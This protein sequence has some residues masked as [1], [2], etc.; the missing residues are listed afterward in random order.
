[1]IDSGVGPMGSVST[2][3][4]KVVPGAAAEAGRPAEVPAVLVQFG[5]VPEI[6]RFE[7][8]QAEP[9]T[10]GMQ[11]VVRSHRGLQLGRL[12]Q[13]A[14]ECSGEA[15]VSQG[16][17]PDAGGESPPAGDT[18]EGPCVLR[19]ATE[20]DLKAAV[21]QQ[22][23]AEDDFR[24]WAERISQWQLELELV[25]I[26][27]T[28][29]RAKLILYVLNERGPDCTRLAIQAA[30][31]GLGLVEVQPVT[32]EGPAQAEAGG[33]GCGSGGCGSGG[34]GSRGGH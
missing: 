32:A 17:E 5:R 29:D 3:P 18:A 11:V 30:A 34:C 16:A 31:A 2:E 15:A 19:V 23:D 13:Q 20:D 33:G 14:G 1:M 9:A 8:K 28:L 10:H 25:D 6:G 7:W 21:E 24:V 4:P 22:L 12:L 27:W 26:E